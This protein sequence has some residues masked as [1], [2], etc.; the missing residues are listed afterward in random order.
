MNA[1]EDGIVDAVAE[2]VVVV[3]LCGS[4]RKSSYNRALLAA[5]VDLAPER[6]GLK[7][8]SLRKLPPYDADHD[9]TFDGGPYPPLI[10]ELREQIDRSD[11]V[12]IVSPEYNWGPPGFLKNALDWASRPAGRSPFHRKPVALMG[13]APGPAG[14]MR[15]QLQLRQTLW[16]M[17]AYVLPEPDVQL[18]RAAERFNERLE[19]IDGRA[20]ELVAAQLAALVEWSERHAVADERARVGAAE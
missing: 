10:E 8:F 4:L 17:R 13:T 7:E 12:L 15:G 5:A 16:A 2:T 11:A 14:T 20:R 3:A 1:S 9:E 6:M 18:G 19:L